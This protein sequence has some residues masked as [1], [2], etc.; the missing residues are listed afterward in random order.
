[1]K[2]SVSSAGNSNMIENWVLVSVSR[3]LAAV[4]DRSIDI[5]LVLDISL[6]LDYASGSC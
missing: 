6:L 3:R 1:V 4:T 2:A 5:D